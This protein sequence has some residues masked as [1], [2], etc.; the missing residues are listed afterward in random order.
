MMTSS[1]NQESHR[2]PSKSPRTSG[3]RLVVKLLGQRE[4]S[5]FLLLFVVAIWLSIRS[6]YF[7]EARNLLNIGRQ[8]S[9]VGIVATAVRRSV[10][11]RR[12]KRTHKTRPAPGTFPV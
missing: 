9:V 3:R 11:F 8:F 2:I 6:P 4:A 10:E 7:L 5:V 12:K 1:K